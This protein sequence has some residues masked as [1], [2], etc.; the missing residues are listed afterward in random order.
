MSDMDG[1]RG[2]DR[3]ESGSAISDSVRLDKPACAGNATHNAVRISGAARCRVFCQAKLPE[4]RL[5]R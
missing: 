4:N 2:L 3:C 1:P 5:Y